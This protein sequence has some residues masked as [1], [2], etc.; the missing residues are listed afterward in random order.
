VTRRGFPWTGTL[1]LSSLMFVAITSEYLPTGLL[2]EIAQN[3]HVTE[4]QVGILVTTFAVTVIISS[5]PLTSITRRVAR[6][7]LL[8]W[9]LAGFALGNVLAAIAINYES[10][11]AARVITGCA[12]GLFSAVGGA[13]VSHM[14][15]KQ[16]LSRA[17]AIVA[18]GAS[19]AFVLGVPLG[20]LLGHAVGWR[21]AFAVAGAIVVP[22]AVLAVTRLPAV[23][24][25]THETTDAIPVP[26]HRDPTFASI[27]LVCAIIIVIML[28][29]NTLYTYIAPFLI[30]VGG[31]PAGQ[32][33]LALLLYGVAGVI[34]LVIAGILGERFPRHGVTGVTVCLAVI[35]AALA[36]G[37]GIP[38]FLTVCLVLWGAAIGSVSVM[39]Q[40]QM[41]H[42]AS[43][44][45]RDLAASSLSTAYNIAIAGGALVGAYLVDRDGLSP[46]PWADLA[47]VVAAILLII[48][49]DR[50]IHRRVLA[51][52]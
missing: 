43:P 13:Y 18:A 33:G 25:R 29:Q 36:L 1:V 34:G 12:Q 3:L 7:P 23:D 39:L 26:L 49:S 6:K 44:R 45:L 5:W 47:F 41:L 11:F 15:P 48:V 24:H 28:G 14:V 37:T 19:A 35:I 52:A 8:I 20:T 21:A 17:V 51:D 30:R 10:L 16:Q 32:V 46:L 2:P 9:A 40:T 4:P 31:V 50:V 27:A 22:L 42:R 38:W